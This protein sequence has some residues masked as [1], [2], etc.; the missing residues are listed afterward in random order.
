[1][2]YVILGGQGMLGHDLVDALAGRDVVALGHAD[3]DVTDAEAVRDAVAGAGAVINAAAY[4]RVDDAETDEQT[5]HAVNA[6][7]AENAAAGAAAAGAAFVQISTDYVFD[8]TSTEPYA[9]DA[10]LNPLGAYGRTKAEGERRVSAAHPSPHLVRT[11]W[12]YGERGRSFPTTIL[13]LA[14]ER[15]TLDVIDDQV[16]QPTWTLDLAQAIVALL[17]A[18]TAPGIYHYTNSGRATW[19]DLAREVFRLA[20]LDPERVQPTDSAS[21]VRPAPRPAFSVLGHAAWTRAG[22]AAPRPWQDALADAFAK[23]ALTT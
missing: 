8:G 15:E 23:G 18:P 3:L 22:L 5:A 9:E 12:L 4:T 2:K 20:G 7:G 16:G 19:F 14:K 10:P 21:F 13:G 17:D 11:A 6:V 1:M